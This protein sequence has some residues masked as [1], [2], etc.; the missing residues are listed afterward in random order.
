MSSTGAKKRSG[1]LLRSD[2]NA[3]SNL[4]DWQQPIMDVMDRNWRQHWGSGQPRT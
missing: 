4:G 2:S 3:D 1:F